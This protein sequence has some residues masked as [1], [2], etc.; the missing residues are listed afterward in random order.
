MANRTGIVEAI[1]HNLLLF[2]NSAS[3]MEQWDTIYALR[4]L[5]HIVGQNPVN[6]SRL[7]ALYN[8]IADVLEHAIQD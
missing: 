1:P 6:G 4:R 3:N 5:A 8:D 7:W 2:E